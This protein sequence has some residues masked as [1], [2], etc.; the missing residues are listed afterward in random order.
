M[1]NFTCNELKP[2]SIII[3]L[4][5]VHAFDWDCGTFYQYF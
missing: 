1:Y 2:D 4:G 3:K 5:P